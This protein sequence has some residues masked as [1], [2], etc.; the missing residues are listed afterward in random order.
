MKKMG[1]MKKSIDGIDSVNIKLFD[2]FYLNELEKR[3]ETD[4][5]LPDGLLDFISTSAPSFGNMNLLCE[6]CHSTSTY[7]ICIGGT[8]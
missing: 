1:K 6:G 7:T 2:K 4:P 5:L 8:Y 3:L